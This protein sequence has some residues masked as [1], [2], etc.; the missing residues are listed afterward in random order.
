MV[1]QI[2]KFTEIES[3]EELR[4]LIA[5]GFNPVVPLTWWAV[6]LKSVKIIIYLN[7]KDRFHFAVKA[8]ISRDK[9]L[10]FEKFVE[11]MQHKNERE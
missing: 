9:F 4:R 7:T 5:N 11:L 10:P 1:A 2:V 3:I 8:S 6:R